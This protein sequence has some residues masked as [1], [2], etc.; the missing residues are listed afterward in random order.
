[1]IKLDNINKYFNRHRSNVNHVCKDISLEFADK[2]LVVILGSSGSGKTTLL[3]IISGMDKF[4]SGVL[5]FDDLEFRKYKSNKWDK[6]RK[7]TIGY[8][9]QNFHLLNDLSVYDNIEIVLKMN[10]IDND[11]EIKSRITY[12]LA[13]IGMEN[14]EDRLAKQLSGGQQQRVA[15]AR[16]LAK[17]PD[18]ILAD[19]PTGN[20]DSKTTIDL[21]NILKSISKEK[22]VV[23][24]THEQA[25]ADFYADRIIEID[26]GSVVKDFINKKNSNLSVIQEQMIY[27][28]D[29]N[30]NVVKADNIDLTSYTDKDADKQEKIDVKL[31]NRYDTLY[32]KI[33]S[34][35]IKRVKYIDSDS[36]IELRDESSENQFV[37]D[38]KLFDS[39]KFVNES[40]T[41]KKKHAITLKDSFKYAI[42]KLNRLSNGGKMLYVVLGLVGVIIAISTGLI[43]EVYNFDEQ[44][45][46]DQNRNYLKVTVK[47]PTYSE[48]MDF[49]DIDGVEQVMLIEEP[50]EFSISTEKY[51]QITNSVLINAH[52]VDI[53]F[54]DESLLLYGTIPNGYGII[55]DVSLADELIR[56]YAERGIENYQD[57]L[58]CGFKLQTSGQDF[59]IAEETSISYPITGIANDGSPS[60]WMDDAL[61]YSFAL[62]TLVDYHI[63]G[64]NFNVTTGSLPAKRLEV[65][66]NVNSPLIRQHEIPYSVGVL[67]STSSITGTF[68]Y[69]V[70]GRD[71][72]F[73]NIMI[74]ELEY[75]HMEYFYLYHAYK[76]NYGVLLY[77]EDVEGTL[78]R[79][80][81]L[82]YNAESE[83]LDD[84]EVFYDYKLDENA[85]FY[86][87]SIVGIVISSVSIFFIMRSSLISRVYEVSVY[88]SLGA[89]KNE[90]RKMFFVEIILTTSFSSVVGYLLM[91]LLLLRAE[92][93]VSDY[94][95]IVHYPFMALVYGVLGLYLVNIIFGLLPVNTLLRKTPS[96]IMTKYDL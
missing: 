24:V 39:N 10:G 46:V 66:I 30:K 64:S 37:I 86:L 93:T 49:E 58:D 48:I 76:V 61:I 80:L 77:T 53:K 73:S 78:E 60:V 35:K 87:F 43:G 71:Y 2:G 69:E 72:D 59:Y 11:E 16:A 6:I 45:F 19:E 67:S 89:S 20:L 62:P 14:Y 83:Y 90:V 82:G 52:P 85:N 13:M 91:V 57:I 95:S 7:D 75:M 31:I 94:I 17:N 25:L 27:L 42:R 23:M 50:I 55:I 33:D 79:L 51:Y 38:E 92:S 81:D 12:L 3:N 96:E 34:D 65:L 18:I 32:V 63:L 40:I 88:R 44:L 74:S 36:E 68:S 4:N 84:Y 1:M 5:S 22:L 41:K 56:K 15:F 29:Y 8:I 54:F 47:N 26:N 28:K 9:Y 21:M 70:N